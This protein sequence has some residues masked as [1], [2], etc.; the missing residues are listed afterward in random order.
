MLLPHVIIKYY[1]LIWTSHYY[2]LILSYNVITQCPYHMLA[3]P[4]TSLPNLNI[5]C[6]FSIPCYQLMLLSNFITPCYHS[7]LSSYTVITTK[8]IASKYMIMLCYLLMLS[9]QCFYFYCSWECEPLWSDILFFWQKVLFRVGT[10]GVQLSG[11]QKQ[12]IAIARALVRNPAILLLDEATSALD[13]E[14]EK[15]VQVKIL[16]ICQF[17]SSR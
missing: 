12:R 1:H 5:S 4:F 14:S 15:I 10:R 6:N 8:L 9:Y 11:G 2:L 13:M 7:M 3:S 16:N 17:R